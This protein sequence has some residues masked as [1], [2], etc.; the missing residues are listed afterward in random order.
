MDTLVV[1]SL[2]NDSAQTPHTVFWRVAFN[3]FKNRIEMSSRR[4]RSSAVT[5][6]AS[7]E[8]TS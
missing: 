6:L 8:Q 4:E 3:W 7:V 5:I 1:S 2:V